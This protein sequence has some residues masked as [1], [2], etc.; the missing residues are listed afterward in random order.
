MLTLDYI[1]GFFDG[2]GSVIVRL[3]KDQR[4]RAG[5][6]LVIK[7]A[8]HQKSKDILEL[9]NQKL[10]IS[11]KIYYHSRDKL[12]YL[13]IYR[14]EDIKR[15]VKNLKDRLVIKKYQ[16]EKLAQILDLVDK[17]FHLDPRGLMLIEAVWRAPKTGV[18]PP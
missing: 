2:E 6:Q 9:I 15:F 14:L 12:W 11:G 4:Y 16:I 10:G 18:K 7:I 13:E 1:A 3:K 5:Y 17:K 8:I